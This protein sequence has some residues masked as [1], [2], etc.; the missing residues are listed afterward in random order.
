MDSVT[1]AD[2]IR[3]IAI[4]EVE[5]K[6]INEKPM[7]RKEFFIYFSNSGMNIRGCVYSNAS[8]WKCIFDVFDG[9]IF[10]SLSALSTWLYISI[11]ASV[12]SNSDVHQHFILA[13]TDDSRNWSI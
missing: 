2:P 13:S 9:N 6:H 10:G 12:V 1:T 8:E 11:H 5:L 7:A 4:A 3:D